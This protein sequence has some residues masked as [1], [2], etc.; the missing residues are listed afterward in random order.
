MYDWYG[1][2]YA[3]CRSGSI[4]HSMPYAGLLVADNEVTGHIWHDY[5]VF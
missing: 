1:I 2:A 4:V 5:Q 3:V